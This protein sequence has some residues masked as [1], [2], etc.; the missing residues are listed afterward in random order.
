MLVYPV[1][2]MHT[3]ISIYMGRGRENSA[4]TA[5]LHMVTSDS[6]SSSTVRDVLFM[7]YSTHLHTHG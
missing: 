7:M 5:S 2:V 3:H 4:K 1:F 6:V